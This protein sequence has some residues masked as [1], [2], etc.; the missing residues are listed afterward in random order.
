M[1]ASGSNTPIGTSSIN[2]FPDLNRSENKEGIS[3]VWY[4]RK[5]GTR[6]SDTNHV[7]RLSEINDY[8]R[9]FTNQE[10]CLNYIQST[11]YERIILIISGSDAANFLPHVNFLKQVDSLFNT[12]L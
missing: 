10:I 1:A 9:V 12:L 2:E 4:D 6:P 5:I 7:R 3:I 11:E 8:V